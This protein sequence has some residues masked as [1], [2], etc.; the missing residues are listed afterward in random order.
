MGNIDISQYVML[1]DQV[2]LDPEQFYNSFGHLQHPRTKKPVKELAPY[3]IK[4]WKAMLEQ[5]RV[6]V[7]KT[8]K[9]GLSTSQLMA[10]FQLA[11]LPSSHPLSTRGYDTL[12]V[13]QTK[14]IAKELLRTLR[15]M[16]LHSKKYS[17]YLIDRP[18]EI[19]EFG[20]GHISYQKIMRDEQTKTSVIYIR[21]PEDETR[22]SR[23]I[24]LGADNP[25]SIESWPNIHHIHI[26]DITATIGDYSDSLNVAITRLANTGGTMV[27]ESIP[28]F[29]GSTL[30]QLYEKYQAR[31]SR[32]AIGQDFATFEITADEAVAAGV[33]TPEHLASERE[34]LG[35]L[36]PRYYGAKFLSSGNAWYDESLIQYFEDDDDDEEEEE[37]EWEVSR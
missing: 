10:D 20:S 12:L 23:I 25:G 6:L 13:S 30:H 24:A 4:V 29:A 7:V 33:M 37:T 3:Q 34:R 36:F 9:C 16:I 19:E 15:R 32:L 2:P 14:D 22:P 27:I 5:R 31:Q 26:S 8:H 35:P 11:V 1:D 28:D 17:K 18:T 21:N